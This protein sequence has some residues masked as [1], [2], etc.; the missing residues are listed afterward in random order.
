MNLDVYPPTRFVLELLL[1]RIQPGCVVLFDELHEF[2]GWR[3]HELRV[4]GEAWEQVDYAYEV[5]GPE[6]ALIQILS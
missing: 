4:L 1:E 6:Q 3:S 5:L 2:P